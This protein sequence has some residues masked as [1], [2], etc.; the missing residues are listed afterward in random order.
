M[1]MCEIRFGIEVEAPE[2]G[3]QESCKVGE[4]NQVRSRFVARHAHLDIVDP[5]RPVEVDRDPG[6]FGSADIGATERRANQID[7]LDLW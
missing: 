6:S 5:R 1:E 3:D 7:Q 2:P 4:R